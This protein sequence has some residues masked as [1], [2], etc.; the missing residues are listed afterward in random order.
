M[1]TT[2][3][4]FMLLSSLSIFSQHVFKPGYYISENGQKHEV[5]IKDEDWRSNPV[6]FIYKNNE[7]SPEQTATL[8]NVKEFSINGGSNYIKA[9]VQLDQSSLETPRLSRNITPDYLEDTVY[10]LLLA[11]GEAN[12]YYHQGKTLKNFFYSKNGGPIEPLV[13]KKYISQPI[14]FGSQSIKENKYFQQQL[15]RA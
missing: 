4:F 14:N 2:F 13:Y 3:L 10:L 11:E 12:L 9:T 7:N 15:E 6:S 5:L 1:R 8:E